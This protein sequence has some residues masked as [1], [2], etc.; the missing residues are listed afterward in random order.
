[1]YPD[2]KELKTELKSLVNG[3]IEARRLS[4]PRVEEIGNGEGYSRVLRKNLRSLMKIRNENISILNESVFPIFESEERLTPNEVEGLEWLCRQLLRQ[5]PEEDL[6][7]TLLYRASKRLMQDALLSADDDKKV[8]SLNRHIGAC[9]SNLNRFNRIRTSRELTEFYK[10]DGLKAAKILLRYLEHENYRKLCTEE[11]RGAVLAGS[12]FY[13][14]L[15][16]TWYTT[17]EKTND[18]RLQGLIES[19][20]QAEDP[21]YIAHSPGMDWRRHKL[22]TLEH[23]GQLTE[24]GNRWYMTPA[25]C[26]IIMD[27]MDEMKELWEE[28][29]VKGEECLPRIHMELIYSRNAYYSGRKDIR[30]YRRDLIRLYTRYANDGY[31]MYSVLANLFLPTEYLATI[32]VNIPG[33]PVRDMLQGVYRWITNYILSSKVNEAYSF[34]LEYLNAFLERFLELPGE[35][36]FSDM[37]LQILAALNPPAYFHSIQMAALAK[38]L[39]THLIRSAPEELLGI[40]GLRSVEEIKEKRIFLLNKAYNA[41]LYLDVGKIP[42]MD[43]VII[44]GRDRMWPEQEAIDMHP[45]IGADLLGKHASTVEYAQITAA[46][47]LSRRQILDSKNGDESTK[48]YALICRMAAAI[49]GMVTIRFGVDDAGEVARDVKKEI[50]EGSGDSYSPCLAKLFDLPD[51]MRDLEFLLGQGTEDSYRNTYLLLNDVRNTQKQDVDAVL[52]SFILRTARI[53]ELSAPQLEDI[54]DPAEYGILLKQHF[55]EIGMLATENKRVLERHVYPLLEQGRKLSAKEAASLKRFCDDLQKGMDL[56]DIDQGLVYRLSG[57]LL[58]DARI[59]GNI[60]ELVLR[61]HNHIASCYEMMHQAKR[62]KTAEEMTWIYREEGL[63]AAEEIWSFLDKN[64]YLKLDDESRQAVLINSRYALFFYETDYMTPGV[65]E[66]FLKG[67]AASYE[68][69]DDPFYTENTEG[70]DWLYHRIR[71]IEYMGQSTECGNLRKFTKE[72]CSRITEWLGVLEGLWKTDPEKCADILPLANIR[73]MQ[74]RTAYH[75]GLITKTQYREKMREIYLEN[76]TYHYDFYSVFPSLDAPLE[77]L[78]TYEG[79][80]S[81][82]AEEKS[83]LEEMYQWVISYILHATNNDSFSLLLEYFSEIIYHFVE[84]EGGMSFK[85]MG[86]YTMATLHPPTYIHSMLVGELARC[87]CRHMLRL[88]PSV[89]IGINGYIDE[90]EVR[91]NAESLTE[92]CYG[93]ALCHDFGKIPMIDTV[94]VYGRKL[95]DSEFAL[96]KHHPRVG[97]MLLAK[98]P[99][100]ARYSRVAL[101]HHKWYD[102]TRGYPEEYD[103]ADPED[104]ILTDIVAAADCMDAATDRVGRSYTGGKRPAEIIKEII[105]GAGSRYSPAVAACLED[106]KAQTEVVHILENVRRE[107]YQNTFLLLKSVL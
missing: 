51:F 98:Y 71:C 21:W 30:E 79:Q 65:N 20:K 82:S 106:T 90:D 58:Q 1:M 36:D 42:V 86:L 81:Y 15:Y 95:L 43:T 12:R 52:E 85:Q 64:R 8:I 69:A 101:G 60:G 56:G 53:R 26:R 105:D 77:L 104:K 13:L 29:E 44:Y 74:Q 39:M 91:D 46:H 23:M 11:G 22:R 89:F 4:Q 47:D 25:Q 18:I 57:R 72:Q 62:M 3:L 94:F 55:Q 38:C 45:E 100:T 97:E 2:R 28:D 80:E 19:L 70:Y 17:D 68:L 78:L 99:S 16:D 75:A 61:L 7:L 48:M 102:N 41:A 34:M 103:A 5:W 73:L 27:Y 31:D 66:K 96:L 92:L 88:N 54:G 59:R 9:Y 50:Q 32:G 6:D 35:Y 37:V 93:A 84:I 67:L 14:A 24:N 10:N 76:R 33:E 87:I 63:G 49:E 83:E 107:N 40:E